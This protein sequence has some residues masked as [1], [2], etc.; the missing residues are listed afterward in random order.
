MPTNY[1]ILD[2]IIPAHL[3][4]WLEKCVWCAPSIW[5]PEHT[6]P[7]YCFLSW[8][9]LVGLHGF[10]L[11]K[12][13]FSQPCNTFC[14]VWQCQSMKNIPPSELDK[15]K[16]KITGNNNL[17]NN[18]SRWALIWPICH[19]YLKHSEKTHITCSLRGQV[20]TDFDFWCFFC[21]EAV[22]Y[23]MEDKVK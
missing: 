19:N 20:E 15:R 3:E 11:P 22:H 5:P 18:N 21:N 16:C 13:F 4:F 2:K 1:C 7:V 10:Y 6:Y 14:F 9:W 8:S 23:R 12:S 17:R